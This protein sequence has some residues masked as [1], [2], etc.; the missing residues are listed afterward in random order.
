MRTYDFL[1][2]ETLLIDKPLE[3]TSF[4]VAN[5]VRNL[6][7]RHLGINKIKVGHA[8]TL[9]PL[10]TGLLIICT[11]KATKTIDS[12]Q[13]LPKR[14]TGTIR[15]G[16]TTP[17]FDLE[18]EV[19]ATY[20]TSHLTPRTIEDAAY[21]LSGD[22][23][24]IPPKFSAKKIDGKQAY[25][26]ARKGEEVKMRPNPVTIHQFDVNTTELP[27][28]YFDIKCSK[29]TYIRA[30]ARDMGEAVNSGGHLAKLRRTAIG[31]HQVGDAMSI[32]DLMEL[33]SGIAVSGTNS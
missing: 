21:R 1:A 12:F 26:L 18:T 10:A 30:V 32:P 9:D 8:G 6:I 7:R 22:Q 28:V 20:P 33:I 2:G 15:L 27:D 4:D 25:L 5:K 24:Q 11:G 13:G 16:A 23:L 31:E 3:W 29:G 14:Y 17:S 19:D